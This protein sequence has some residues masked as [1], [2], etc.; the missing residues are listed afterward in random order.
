MRRSQVS[1]QPGTIQTRPSIIEFEP[2]LSGTFNR[3]PSGLPQAAVQQNPETLRTRGFFP[4][5]TALH[6][7]IPQYPAL[8]GSPDEH[9][10]RCLQGFDP[11][12]TARGDVL[13]RPL[14]RMNSSFRTVSVRYKIQLL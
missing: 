11:V 10:C 14:E 9:Q 2:Q 8:Q 1:P 13:E 5:Q 4:W 3:Y 6:T 7:S 12:V